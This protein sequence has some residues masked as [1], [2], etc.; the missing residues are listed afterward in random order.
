MVAKLQGYAGNFIT[1]QMAAE[2]KQYHFHSFR[3]V[4]TRVEL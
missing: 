3:T 1:A 2:N 4:H